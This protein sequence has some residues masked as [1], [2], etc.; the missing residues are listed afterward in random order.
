[1]PAAQPQIP[2]YDGIENLMGVNGNH[3][4]K[5]PQGYCSSAVNRDF[6]YSEN[7]TRPPIVNTRLTFP[8]DTTGQVQALFE[9]GN[10][11]GATVWQSYP[12]FNDSM[13]VICIAGTIFY[14]VLTGNTGQV[15]QLYTGFDPT[16]THAWFAQGFEY[17]F[18]QNGL[19]QPF[20]WNGIDPNGGGAPGSNPVCRQTNVGDINAVDASGN[21]TNP[22][23]MPIGSVMA[24]IYGMMVVSSAD[25]TN[26][27]V[28][29]DSAYSDGQTTTESIINFTDTTYWAEGG[30][31]G[32][33]IFQGDITGMCAAPYLDTGTGQNELIVFGT[34]GAISMDLSGARTTW[35]TT[36]VIR[37]S[38]IGAGCVSADSVC[39]MNGDVFYRS[40]E[41]IRSFKNSRLEFQ[42][43]WNQAPVSLDARRWL[44]YDRPDLRQYCSQITWNNRLLCTVSP[45]L[46]APNNP[47]AGFHRFHRGIVVMDAEPQSTNQQNSAAQY[48]SIYTGGAPI[49]DGLWTGIRPTALV[50]GRFSGVNRSFAF[51][52]DQD[53]KNRLYEFVEYGTDDFFQSTPVKV[54]SSFD[55]AQ[56]GGAG[57]ADTNAF[58]PKTMQA[59]EIEL[60]GIR[61]AVQVCVSIKPDSSPCFVKLEEWTASCDACPAT[62]SGC[63]LPAQAA[64]QRRIFSGFEETCIPGTDQLLS[65]LR[66]WQTRVEMT[67][68]AEVERMAFRFENN[69]DRRM[70]QNCE[71][72]RIC[73]PT[74][75]CPYAGEYAYLIAPPGQNTNVPF[76]PQPSDVAQSWQATATFT[77]TCPGGSSGSS[78]TATASYTSLISQNDAQVNAN[79]LAQQKAAAG[80]V[81]SGCTPQTL[82]TFSCQ[83]STVNLSA[84]FVSGYFPAGGDDQSWRLIDLETDAIYAS[85]IVDSTGTL[86]VL[87]ALTTG[88]ETFD[89]TTFIFTSSGGSLAAVG[90]EVAC[91]SPGGPVFPNPTNPYY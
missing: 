12:S 11:Q 3:P 30:A 63:L 27:I 42:Q 26:Q 75:C 65:K 86:D 54:T 56:M 39:P 31:F 46:A 13:I 25:G 43:T 61:E 76:I 22:P 82:I 36:Q 62:P 2:L 81:C 8:G 68:R 84:F 20:V 35:Q 79:T 38:L 33:P 6:R 69:P 47:L 48:L 4:A 19:Q 67:G 51:S 32:F 17:L 88:D 7:K 41:G 91:N 90:L 10:V 21:Y 23:E 18:M 83:N 15:Y 37:V 53:G 52:Y 16:L 9:G 72:D 55:T 58:T 85:G 78:V 5:I 45:Q 70:T 1:M 77:A 74:F 80:L 49:W 40:D 29:G 59:G 60:S 64:Y 28:V 57:Q 87:Y 66:H 71:D 89:A 14:I 24:F 50:Q 73:T 34:D 44:Q